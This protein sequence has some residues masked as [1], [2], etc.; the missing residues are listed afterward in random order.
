MFWLRE[1]SVVKIP[2]TNAIDKEHFPESDQ[3]RTMKIKVYDYE[4]GGGSRLKPQTDFIL[5]ESILPHV[6]K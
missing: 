5:F 6:L 4:R 1:E 2:F 3:N